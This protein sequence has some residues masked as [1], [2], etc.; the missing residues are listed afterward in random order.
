MVS[1]P[2]FDKR[3]AIIGSTGSGKTQFA[4]WLLSSRDF[5]I[6]PWIIFDFKGDG[7]IEEIG[8][9]EISIRGRVPVEPGLYV[10]R[11]I[12]DL[13]DGYVTNFLW[14]I[15]RNGN[16]GI[17]IDEGYMVGNRNPALNA[18]LT[19]GRSKHIEMITLSQRPVW[20]SRFVFSEANFFAVFNLTVEDD[21]KHINNFVPNTKIGL[22]P[23]YHCLWYDVDAQRASLFKPVPDRQSI[24]N[25]FHLR[26]GKRVKRI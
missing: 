6:R 7:L 18:C 15:W 10:V 21:R 14:E 1:L 12:P 26:R 17:Y 16:T 9:Q 2:R 20:M 11:P 4:V 19:Q 25:A 5:N 23:K 22:L 8:A 24:I 3:T 13:D